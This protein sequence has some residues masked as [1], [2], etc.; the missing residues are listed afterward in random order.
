M[1]A[2][3]H[4]AFLFRRASRSRSVGG[5]CS[6]TPPDRGWSLGVTFVPMQIVYDQRDLEYADRRGDL[7][8]GWLRE[9]G[10]IPLQQLP[11]DEE[12]FLFGYQ[13]PHEQ[14]CEIVRPF[15]KIRDRPDE[16]QQLAR[17]E[18]ILFELQQKGVTVPTPRTWVLRLDDAPPA[19]LTFPLFVRTSTSSWK[20]GG[21]IS[22]VRN[23]RQLQDECDMLRR[24]FRWDAT[25]LAREW[26][27]LMIAG[28]WRYGKIPREVRV[29]IVDSVPLAWSFHYL[30]VVR[31]PVGFPPS[32][33]DLELIAQLAQKIAAPF[34]SR[35]VAADFV[36]DTASRWHFLEA[37]PGACSGTAHEGVFKTVASKLIALELAWKGDMVGGPLPKVG[38]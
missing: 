27:D 29:W 16:R 28:E 30:H 31:D 12:A 21:Q 10:A 24:A 35:L 23:L 32:T 11:P 14:Y 15:A 20:R 38:E 9:I 36:C 34:S 19:D 33:A 7:R 37:G 3:G 25:I 26:I 1:Q 22:K 18:D 4:E 17:L 2:S 8:L 6:G 5:L 13:I